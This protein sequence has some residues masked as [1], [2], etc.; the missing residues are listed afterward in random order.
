M[1]RVNWVKRKIR[2]GQVKIFHRIYV[3]VDPHYPYNGELDG[4]TGYFGSYPE[5]PDRVS[6]ID[7]D[8]APWDARIAPIS[9][10]IKWL[11]WRE[12]Q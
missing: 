12:K 2:N 3:P 9:G 1:K 5:T 6:L 4:F 11:W 10:V 7:V 8:D